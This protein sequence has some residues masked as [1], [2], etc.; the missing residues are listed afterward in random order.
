[1]RF[2]I[3]A[4]AIATVFAVGLASPAP[5]FAASKTSAS[6][7]AAKDKASNPQSFDAC[8]ALAKQRGWNSA[9]RY[10]GSGVKEFVQGCMD[11]KQH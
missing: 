11:G 1:M 7:Q 2:T 6:A 3:P 5:S 9:D 10:A 8:V 4:L